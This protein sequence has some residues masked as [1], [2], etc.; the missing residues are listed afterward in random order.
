[1]TERIQLLSAAF[2][3]FVFALTFASQAQQT[4]QQAVVTGKLIATYNNAPAPGMTV[5]LVHPVL[6]RSAPAISDNFG[7][8]TLRG[9]PIR[10]DAYYLEVY[11]GNQL[12]NR[13]S[14]IVNTPM[15]DLNVVQM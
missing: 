10:S 2:L 12:I 8:F 7:T 4:R 6:G 15:L 5:S 9:I 3:F 14:I 13:Q 11:W 1:M